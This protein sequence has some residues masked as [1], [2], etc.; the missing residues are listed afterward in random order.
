MSEKLILP[1]RKS[2]VIES[3]FAICLVLCLV[4]SFENSEVVSPD[5]VLYHELAHNLIDGDGYH[6]NIRNDFILPSIGHPLLILIAES[7][8]INNPLSFAR[9]LLCIGLI[10]A[11][12]TAKKLKLP[13]YTPIFVILLM[14]AIIPEVYDWGVELSLFFSINLVLFCIVRF[15]YHTDIV[16]A[17]FLGLAM[18]LNLL[19][20]PIYSPLIYLS[21]LFAIILLIKFKTRLIPVLIS[22]FVAVGI[23]NGVTLFSKAKF[24]DKRLSSGTYSEIPLYCANNKY[25]ELKETYWSSRWNELSAEE[26]SKAVGPLQ[27]T[28]TWKDRADTLRKEVIYFY[29]THPA[30][31]IGGILWRASRFTYDQPKAIG[32]ILF[33][34][35]SVMSLSL[36]WHRRRSFL[37]VKKACN[38][39]W[40]GAILPVYTVGVLSLFVYAGERY[41]L[42]TNLVFIL[43]ILLYIPVLQNFLKE[44]R[45]EKLISQEQP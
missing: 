41:N 30:K 21:I 40:I 33:I 23:V 12:F 39:Y 35:W 24:G 3:I 25:L 16:S 11:F 29:K 22:L 15:V 45:N 8:G 42:S 36:F 34:I 10:I 28:T 27:I 18:A 7:L 37:F 31:A 9:I 5:G 20:R 19:I 1:Q 4:F 2:V 13:R 32:T 17:I 38:L 43:G 14:F 44:R 26:Y 6:D